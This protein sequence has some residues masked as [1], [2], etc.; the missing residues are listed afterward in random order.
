MCNCLAHYAGPH[1]LSCAPGYYLKPT[2]S[3]TNQDKLPEDMCVS[4]MCN[5]NTL[6]DTPHCQDNTGEAMGVELFETVNTIS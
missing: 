1:C 4:C 3:I 5:G 2:Q 6:T